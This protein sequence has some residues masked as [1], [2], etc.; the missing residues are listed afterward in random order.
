MIY[1]VL[2]QEEGQWKH[3][4]EPTLQD[5]QELRNSMLASGYT[6]VVIERI[7]K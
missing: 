2:Y 1:R 3:L 4:D 7:E 6:E 5:A